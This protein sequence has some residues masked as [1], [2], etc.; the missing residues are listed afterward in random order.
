[1]EWG[2]CMEESQP[3]SLFARDGH[4]DQNRMRTGEIGIKK[5]F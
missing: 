3:A 4:W 1:M 5:E 2:D